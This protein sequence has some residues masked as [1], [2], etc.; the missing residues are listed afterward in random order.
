MKIMRI[1]RV[2]RELLF[3]VDLFVPHTFVIK[4]TV[5]DTALYR[6]RRRKKSLVE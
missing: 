6:L 3:V 5:K 1:A 2:Q 4:D